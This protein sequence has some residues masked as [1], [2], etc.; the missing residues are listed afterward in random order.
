M[1]VLDHASPVAPS[2]HSLAR[3]T[4]VISLR[5]RTRATMLAL[6]SNYSATNTKHPRHAPAREPQRSAPATPVPGLTA[7]PPGLMRHRPA[8]D[9][10]SRHRLR[11]RRRLPGTDFPFQR[12]LRLCPAP[13]PLPGTASGSPRY[14]V[15]DP[16]GPL[17]S[18]GR[19]RC[20]I[21]VVTEAVTRR[22]RI[23]EAPRAGFM[24]QEGKRWRSRGGARTGLGAVRGSDGARGCTGLGAGRGPGLGAVRGSGPDE[25]RGSGPDEARGSGPDEARGSGLYGAR[26][27]T[28]PGARGRT[29]PG[30][31][32]CTGLG[33]GRGPGLGAGR[34]GGAGRGPGLGA[35]RGG[36]RADSGVRGRA[37]RGTG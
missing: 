17:L 1:A 6:T 2:N 26:G 14:R 20:A 12:P 31:R 32:G 25:A 5:I 21:G 19:P 13:P 9:S 7:A 11:L 37:R 34:G 28:R 8:P 15:N 33:A 29:R 22:V 10:A 16:N 30:A 18:L 4:V 24:G 35:G 3:T 36:G 27:R 23:A